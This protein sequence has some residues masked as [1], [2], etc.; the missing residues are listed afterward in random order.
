[1]SDHA[2]NGVKQIIRH[3]RGLLRERNGSGVELAVEDDGFYEEGGWLYLVVTPARPGIRAFEYVERL[4]ELER[5]LR[6]EFDNPN[7]LLV[8]AWGD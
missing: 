3:L 8:P 4:Q 6:R 2:N 1:M 5:E 7:I